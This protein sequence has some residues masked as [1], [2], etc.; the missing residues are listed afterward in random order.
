MRQSVLK[1][2]QLD[3]EEY[4]AQLNAKLTGTESQN[5]L[6]LQQIKSLSSEPMPDPLDFNA[7]KILFEQKLRKKKGKQREQIQNELLKLI[8]PNFGE[9]VIF[10]NGE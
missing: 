3:G 1:M 8:P 10:K 7:K 6:L 9:P 4:A 5:S 2:L